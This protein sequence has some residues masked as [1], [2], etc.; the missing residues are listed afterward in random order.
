VIAITNRARADRGHIG[1][2]VGFADRHRGD[3][4]A[5]EDLRE[6]AL[7]LR[8]SARVDQVR[9][10]H[11]GVHQH[12]DDESS[13][14][15]TR[16]RLLED[17]VGHHVGAGATIGFGNRQS[18]PAERAHRTQHRTRHETL[19]VPR[20]SVRLDLA[21]DEARYF[22]PQLLVLGPGVDR[23]AHRHAYMRNTPNCVTGIGAFNAAERPSARHMRVSSGSITPSSQS[24]ALA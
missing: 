13:R 23:V 4:V 12:G 22:A 19:R 15:R 5:G 16:Q 20:G 2:G 17:D 7:L 10:R 1:A 8:G 6:P 11:V 18:E 21:R 3:D 9:A 14:C 24:R